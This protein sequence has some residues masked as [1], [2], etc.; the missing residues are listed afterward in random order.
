[1]NYVMM[2]RRAQTD[3]IAALLIEDD[4]V[5]EISPGFEALI[6]EIVERGR[7]YGDNAVQMFQNVGYYYLLPVPGLTLQ[8][9]SDS[10]RLFNPYHDELGRFTTSPDARGAL[11]AIGKAGVLHD[12]KM[13]GYKKSPMGSIIIKTRLNNQEQAISEVQ[14][15]RAF[16]EK[17]LSGFDGSARVVLGGWVPPFAAAYHNTWT[18]AIV[19]GKK[20]ARPL[21]GQYS[22]SSH[23]LMHELVH[24]RRG[25]NRSIS[26]SECESS[27][28][29]I[30]RRLTYKMYG[31]Y[32]TRGYAPLVRRLGNYAMAIN[33]ND[34]GKAW[35][36]VNHVNL[37]T[38][39][40]PESVWGRKYLK[41]DAWKAMVEDKEDYQLREEAQEELDKR[42]MM[43][44]NLLD[45]SR[46]DE[47][48]ALAKA[49]G[50]LD[51]V[52][53][54]AETAAHVGIAFEVRKSVSK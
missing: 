3:D 5:S 49:I 44:Y 2:V 19:I 20:H 11:R 37:G 22:F 13:D 48:M 16:L 27:T 31:H 34:R 23:A 39:R 29:L 35:S 26:V 32:T 42:I 38:E 43:V 51:I 33:D 15:Q 28:D 46:W 52:A 6:P 47:A 18:N 25:V 21:G 24:S 53:D 41:G 1:M 10:L 17:N 50:N 45:E 40:V 30:A 14:K 9:R 4:V 12:P 7:P 54:V 36:Y 8:E